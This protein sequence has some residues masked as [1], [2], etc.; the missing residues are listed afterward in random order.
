MHLALQTTPEDS[1]SFL[2]ATPVRSSHKM[3]ETPE[4]LRGKLAPVQLRQSNEAS[5][6]HKAV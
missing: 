4:K 2:H 1:S 3:G 6:V 5:E